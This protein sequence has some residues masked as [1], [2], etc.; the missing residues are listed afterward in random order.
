MTG[1]AKGLAL[2]AAVALSLGV[3]KESKAHEAH[4][5]APATEAGNVLNI[6]DADIN[7]LR[8][9]GIQTSM[10][11]VLGE[12]QDLQNSEA[13]GP[14]APRDLQRQVSQ[15]MSATLGQDYH[16]QEGSYEAY[17]AELRTRYERPERD[18]MKEIDLKFYQSDDKRETLRVGGPGI[19]YSYE[20]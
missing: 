7:R 19:E 2:M 1:K 20:W 8:A 3:S 16:R 6:T 12:M 13:Y 10:R 4:A 14:A 11:E 15:D 5:T 17:I 9:L 18:G